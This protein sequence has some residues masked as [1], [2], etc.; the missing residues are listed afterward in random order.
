MV[1]KGIVLQF[2]IYCEEKSSAS[3]IRVR[4]RTISPAS[5][6]SCDDGLSSGVRFGGR[7]ISNIAWSRTLWIRSDKLCKVERGSIGIW[8]CR[9]AQH[10]FQI[11]QSSEVNP[12]MES[13]D[14]AFHSCNSASA[15]GLFWTTSVLNPIGDRSQVPLAWEQWKRAWFW[16]M[17]AQFTWWFYL[18]DAS[19]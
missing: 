16:L 11:C 13:S 5:D 8:T 1:S 9:A 10:D 17:M 15:K 12:D 7:G 6:W 4:E 14:R 2:A 3:L 18:G 19:V